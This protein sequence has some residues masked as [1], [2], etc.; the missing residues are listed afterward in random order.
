MHKINFF[1]YFA[2]G[3]NMSIRRLLERCSTANFL[4]IAK[5]EN[6]KLAFNKKSS[7]D[8]SGKANIIE[9]DN[10]SDIVWGVIFEIEESQKTQL[11]EAEGNGYGYDDHTI[12]VIDSK[13]QEHECIVYIATEAKYID[14]SLT[15]MDWYL[16][17]C[18]IGARENGLP[19]DYILIIKSQSSIKDKNIERAQRERNIYN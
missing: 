1:K 2:Y 4:G 10:P 11:D 14:N 8:K 12:K 13:G 18:L 5:I 17:H 9:T 6:Y 16:E 15:P 7:L 19:E 3:S